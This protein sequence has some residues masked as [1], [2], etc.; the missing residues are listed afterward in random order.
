MSL[1]NVILEH[2]SCDFSSAFAWEG[3]LFMN[4]INFEFIYFIV[5]MKLYMSRKFSD[6]DVGY[7]F[8]LF[9]RLQI[10]QYSCYIKETNTD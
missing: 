2:K 5:K 10:F 1:D 4:Q 6:H 7:P 8:I 9:F 3:K